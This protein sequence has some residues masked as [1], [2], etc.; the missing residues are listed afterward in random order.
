[1]VGKGNG[2]E[3]QV[4]LTMLQ[5]EV[6]GRG[7]SGTR[8]LAT[9]CGYVGKGKVGEGDSTMYN[10]FPFMFCLP[11]CTSMHLNDFSIKLA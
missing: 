10:L 3:S 5:S 1:M 4:P 9:S 8:S 7:G 11:F 2:G 6:G